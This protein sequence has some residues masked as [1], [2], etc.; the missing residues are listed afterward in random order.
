MPNYTGTVTLTSPT[1]G[2]ATL[3]SSYTFTASDA[4]K[5]TFQVTFSST[6]GAGQQTVTATD[7]SVQQLTGSVSTNLTSPNV[8]THFGVTIPEN[9]QI[10]VPVEVSVTA[11]N[12]NNRPVSGFTGTVSFAPAGTSTTTSETL[13]SS[14]TFTT[15]H[16]WRGDDGQHEFQ[17]TFNSTGPQSFV[18][19][20]GSGNTSPTVTTNVY[21][22]PVATSLQIVAP[23]NIPAG[24]AVPVTVEALDAANHVVK[25]FT[26]TVSLTGGTA[27]ITGPTSPS[28]GTQGRL[29]FK[30]TAPTGSAGITLTLTAT[31][32]TANLTATAT[33]NVVTP[34][35]HSYGGGGG[36]GL[37]LGGLV[38]RAFR[39]FG[40]NF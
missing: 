29:L 16:W 32:T 10:G 27:T 19:T 20:D 36:G 3:P 8:V 40:R 7:D 30:V 2:S 33:I 17:V 26:D 6:S 14:Y 15:G 35:S 18:V 34:H 11:L 9:V 4:G 37:G 22:A 31:D 5:H 24:V 25:V 38:S 21:A 39:A 28:S 12:A 13:P 1:D 23:E